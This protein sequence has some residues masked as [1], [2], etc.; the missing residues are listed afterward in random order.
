MKKTCINCDSKMPK[1]VMVFGNNGWRCRSDKQCL[2]RA[3]PKLRAMKK[4]RDIGSLMSNVCY[5]FAQL[6]GASPNREALRD[7]QRRWD[8]ADGAIPRG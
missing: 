1:S 4:L 7:L 6:S 3:A 8:E 5:N 2:Q